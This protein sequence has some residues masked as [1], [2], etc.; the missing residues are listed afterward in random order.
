MNW[1]DY[2]DDNAQDDNMEEMF[3]E[4][5]AHDNRP[6]PSSNEVLKH[7]KSFNINNMASSGQQR[8]NN[9]SP[10]VV[11]PGSTARTS[12][13]E[14]L[15][16]LSQS[17]GLP[18]PS[19]NVQNGASKKHKHPEY[20]CSVAVGDFIK[21]SSFPKTTRTEREAE[22][23]AAEK[24]LKELEAKL[25]TLQPSAPVSETP[26]E[27]TG[28]DKVLDRIYDLVKDERV[29]LL[30]VGVIDKY[31]SQFKEPLPSDWID[32]V[33]KDERFAVE[34]N[35]V[36]NRTLTTIS[37]KKP[38]TARSPIPTTSTVPSIPV[39][40][41]A[42]SHSSLQDN[43]LSGGTI[44]GPVIP[45]KAGSDDFFDVFVTVADSPSNFLVQP[46]EQIS[47][48]ES[49]F[50]Q[51]QRD[52]KIY[53][54]NEDNLI[55]LE[56]SSVIRPGFY[57]AAKV[58]DSWRR[59]LIK[60]LVPP[61]AGETESTESLVLVLDFGNLVVVK[62]NNL[63]PLR[64]Q[65]RSLPQQVIHA[66]VF[67]IE[68]KDPSLDWDPDSRSTF[69]KLVINRPLVSQVKGIKKIMVEGENMTKVSLVLIDTSTEEDIYIANL[70]IDR[71]MAKATS[72]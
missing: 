51:L 68:P 28:A 13:R 38:L 22:D 63:Q 3:E 35:A 42:Q 16:S 4:R 55:S 71:D 62:H 30:D 44:P 2:C 26:V 39:Q 10:S 61:A 67:G 53:Y 6:R 32:V 47:N 49:A 20:Y 48:K 52:M 59:V 23:L 9:G 29:G 17:Q 27:T 56:S 40:S 8:V 60:S 33:L 19:Y 1:A 12:A 58:K 14:K 69:T 50:N 66:E 70:L 54:E 24:A 64:Q 5:R 18:P 57:A 25:K 31:Q 11:S 65:F 15:L 37:L 21:V 7:L 45:V 72:S 41:S 43:V 34:V 46:F 36:F